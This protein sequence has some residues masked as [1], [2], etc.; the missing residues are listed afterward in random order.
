MKSPLGVVNG[1]MISDAKYASVEPPAPVWDNVALVHVTAANGAELSEDTPSAAQ[2]PPM[3]NDGTR[4][5]QPITPAGGDGSLLGRC[6]C[7]AL[8]AC[9][10]AHAHAS[11]IGLPTTFGQGEVE[12]MA[13]SIFIEGMRNGS[14]IK[15]KLNKRRTNRTVFCA[16]W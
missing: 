4:D 1:G 6:L 3:A 2:A 8:N 7:E 5:A 15:R 12:C 9:K 13:V 10:I 14:A 16:I 11:A